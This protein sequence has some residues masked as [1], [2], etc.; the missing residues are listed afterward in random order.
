ME[1]S[2]HFFVKLTTLE[3]NVNSDN[4]HKHRTNENRLVSKFSD[5]YIDLLTVGDADAR[6]TMFDE[7]VADIAKR[8]VEVKPDRQSPRSAPRKKKFC[9]R[10][11]RVLR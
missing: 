1:R 7:L 3:K 8:P 9:D 6:L 11:K 2:P 5:Q 10:R 4:K